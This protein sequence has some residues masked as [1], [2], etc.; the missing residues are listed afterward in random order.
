[1]NESSDF[2]FMFNMPHVS[3]RTNAAELFEFVLEL[4][5]WKIEKVF[6]F[7]KLSSVFQ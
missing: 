2:Y 1:M 6:E 3:K 7:E 5:I 4:W